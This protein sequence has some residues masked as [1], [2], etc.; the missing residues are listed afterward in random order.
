MSSAWQ[1]LEQLLT[2]AICMDR[3]K[4]PKLLPCQ[5][6]YCG[7][8]C[9]EGLVD[10]ARRQ[11]K[12]PEC[13]AE[14]RIPYNGIQTLPT[15]VTLMRF[16][17][18]HRSITG[19]EPE[20]EEAVLGRCSVCS[21][22][23]HLVTCHHCGKKICPD[24]KEAHL[25]VMRREIFRIC[26]NVRRSLTRLEDTLKETKKNE[27]KL[28]T[29][30]TN[31]RE[32]IA[33]VIGRSV[34]D[35]ERLKDRLSSEVDSYEE[36]ETGTLAKLSEDL[37]QEFS[38]INANCEVVEKYIDEDHDWTDT[39]LVEYKEIFIKTLE[40]LRNFDADTTDYGRRVRLNILT[41]TEQVHKI[42]T[43]LLELKIQPSSSVNQSF[44]PAGQTLPNALMRSQSD[45]RL[46]SQFKK[47]D[48][49]SMLD[50]SQRD[51]ASDNEERGQGKTDILR[52]YGLLGDDDSHGSSRHGGYKSKYVRDLLQEQES[53]MRPQTAT[54]RFEED[55]IK[56]PE[57]L[58]KVFDVD[59]A[60]RA[61][62]SGIVKIEDSGRFMERV[63]ESQKKAK[64]KREEKEN[65]KRMQEQQQKLTQIA[66]QRMQHQMASMRAQQHTQQR[67]GIPSDQSADSSLAVAG[68]TN[69]GGSGN[70]TGTNA[71][72]SAARDERPDTRKDGPVSTVTSQSAHEEPSKYS[73]ATLRTP[74]LDDDR[75]SDSSSVR[76]RRTYLEESTTPS[77]DSPL[78]RMTSKPDE[79]RNPYRSSSV[80]DYP[81]RTAST[82]LTSRRQGYGL[83][84]PSRVQDSESDSESEESEGQPQTGPVGRRFDESSSVSAL[85]SRSQEVRK[86]MSIADNAPRDQRQRNRS[87]SFQ[88]SR[89]SGYVLG[90]STANNSEDDIS[91]SE[92]EKTINTRRTYS[93][94]SDSTAVGGGYGNPRSA[95]LQK[96]ECKLSIG[97]RGS[98]SGSFTWP[99]S[100]AVGPDGSLVA[101][102]SS[103]HRVQVFDSNGR[104][105][106]AFGKQGSGD[107]E[108]DNPAGLAVNRIGQ[109]I[110]SDR[111]NNRVQIFDSTGRFIRTF[112]GD[113]RTDGKFQCP[114][115]LTTD[116]L[117]FIYVCDKENHRVQVFQSDGS[118]VGK[119]GSVG[120]RPGY[121]E[122]PSY[123][124]VSS[125][126]RVIVS[127]T[128]NHR[129]QVFDVNGRC[130][131]TFGAEGSEEGL[132]RFP[133][134]VA[135]DDQGY[136]VV[137]DSGNNRIQVF[138]P[139]GSF[140]KAFGTW[141]SEGGKFKG[142]EDIA[143]NSKGDIIACDRENHRIQI[144]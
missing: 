116:S 97:K 118:F 6:T 138:Q 93:R 60:A 123:I 53:M 75:G 59:G 139:D 57:Q 96:G 108:L 141:G 8:P 35:L 37:E 17:E 22:K 102:D 68:M 125:T 106:H 76:S 47:V 12:C 51:G 50:I 29:N 110:V 55:K 26:S 70:S 71:S 18:L 73:T 62:L 25:D 45:H 74:S 95:Y 54:S 16:L 107:G 13:R 49:R 130:Q 19:E 140:I 40:F 52:R 2:C 31:V 56:E 101:A 24:C 80:S 28:I 86:N 44:T 15:N 137:A 38:T 119:M 43:G 77:R 114:W 92:Q 79:E 34:K 132:F 58:L 94:G 121:L 65:L 30:C 23:Q 126:N 72:E 10:Y 113:G 89:S 82:A 100:V 5:H 128:N 105:L 78:S 129:V 90:S 83:R 9:M 134:G 39:E 84:Q 112:G 69:M 142:L 127:D 136:I 66:Q 21:E 143:V 67:G 11:I 91:D 144:F 4:N 115:G 14:H 135:V 20:P 120:S 117:G 122:H 64:A 103:N 111:Y 98:E 46:A 3:F 42:L 27:D 131:F 36:T 63:F 99:R 33:D 87:S 48:S 7:D 41:D 88:R 32:E 85:L 133:R 104:F 124:A 1:Q 61:P 81:S 109:I